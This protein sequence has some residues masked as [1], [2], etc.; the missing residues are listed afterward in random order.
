M[1]DIYLKI[2]QWISDPETYAG[3][4][5][6]DKAFLREH[7]IVISS[8]YI[9]MVR[10]YR[11]NEETGYSHV[12]WQTSCAMNLFS[13]MGDGSPIDQDELA[14]QLRNWVYWLRNLSEAGLRRVFDQNI[15]LLST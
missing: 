4:T 6:E 5:D 15:G 3:L 12:I 1:D 9:G 8:A 13:V 2:D 14:S 10:A 11:K 7:D